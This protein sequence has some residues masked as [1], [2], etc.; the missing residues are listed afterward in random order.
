MRLTVFMLLLGFLSGCCSVTSSCDCENEAPKDLF[1]TESVKT[2]LPYQ[3]DSV[4]AFRHFSDS[5]A[6][7][8]GWTWEKG[9]TTYGGEECLQGNTETWD[10]KWKPEQGV[11][12]IPFEFFL[13][14]ENVL[15]VQYITYDFG[16]KNLRV[17]S[18]DSILN[19]GLE[20]S[21]LDSL[22]IGAKVFYHV[23]Q[24]RNPVTDERIYLVKQA[25]I[26]KTEAWVREF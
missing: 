24:V 10:G 26:L 12:G 7:A 1:L 4:Y 5:V 3:A 11:S 2:W 17:G 21:F 13:L 9:S 16:Y 22:Q 20:G 6:V 25:G 23:L 8:F 15:K 14:D 18:D 19:N